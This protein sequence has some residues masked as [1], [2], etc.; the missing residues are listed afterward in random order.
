[1]RGETSG[2]AF[3]VDITSDQSFGS[4]VAGLAMYAVYFAVVAYGV[5]IFTFN[6]LAYDLGGVETAF[7]TWLLLR[8]TR[9]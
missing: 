7:I 9:R 3:D 1:V 6:V 5:R 8:M 4:L 2:H